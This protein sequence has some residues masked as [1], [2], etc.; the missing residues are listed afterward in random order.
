MT[1]WKPIETAPPWHRV[2]VSGWQD[3]TVYGKPSYWWV[4]FDLTD[5]H[6]VPMHYKDAEWWA[7]CPV[8]PDFPAPR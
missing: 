3:E 7:K 6:G 8:G 4:E 2:L 1:D 5:E